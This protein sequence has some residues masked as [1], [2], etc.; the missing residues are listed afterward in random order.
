M[1]AVSTRPATLAELRESSW[2]PRTV[3]DEIHDNLVAALAADE[4]LFPGLPG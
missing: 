2:T 1:P 4:D 3:K